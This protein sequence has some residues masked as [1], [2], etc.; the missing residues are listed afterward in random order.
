MTHIEKIIRDADNYRHDIETLAN[1]IKLL[2][3]ELKK[4]NQIADRVRI[5]EGKLSVMRVNFARYRSEFPPTHKKSKKT[6]TLI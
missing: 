3:K 2:E 4:V 5:A 1:Y 6:L